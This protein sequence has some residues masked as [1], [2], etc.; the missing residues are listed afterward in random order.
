MLGLLPQ[1]LAWDAA[2]RVPADGVTGT[3]RPANF[4]EEQT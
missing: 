2:E 4:E 1:Q 3:A